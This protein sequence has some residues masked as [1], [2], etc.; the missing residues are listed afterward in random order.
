MLAF[1]FD[2]ALVASER[3][4]SLATWRYTPTGQVETRAV[5][6]VAEESL[7]RCVALSG[8]QFAF[9]AASGRVA[10]SSFDAST[11]V[12]R[13]TSELQPRQQTPRACLLLRFTS[14]NSRLLAGFAKQ[15]TEPCLIVWDTTQATQLAQFG[16]N[17][18]LHS[19]AWLNNSDHAFLAAVSHKWIR[20]YD[21]RRM[22]HSSSS[23]SIATDSSNAAG[24]VIATKAVYGIAPDPFDDFRFASYGDASTVCIWDT[25]KTA[26]PLLTLDAGMNTELRGGIGGLDWCPTR[27]GVLASVSKEGG[28]VSVWELME[29]VSES[30]SGKQSP[31]TTSI[32]PEVE[33]Y[34]IGPTESESGLSTP[35][36][37]LLA[38]ETPS[39]SLHPTSDSPTTLLTTPIL[40]KQRYVKPSQSNS[41]GT[42]GLAWLP[43]SVTNAADV[44]VTI[45]S[46]DGTLS[47]HNLMYTPVAAWGA[48]AGSGAGNQ[49]AVGVGA[50]VSLRDIGGGGEWDED[51]AS[52]IK[53][54]AV[55]GYALDIKTNISLLQRKI[56]AESSQ[57]LLE[58]WTFIRDMR[59]QSRHYT[60]NNREYSLLGIH[61]LVC[62]HVHETS[63]PS[64][65]ESEY[66][67]EI[68][69]GVPTIMTYFESYSSEFRTAGL[70]M[71]GRL[72]ETDASLELKLQSFEQKG[73][74]EQAAGFALFYS[75]S[76][77]RALASLNSSKD[78]K[79]RLVAAALAGYMSGGPPPPTWV[80]LCETL[81]AELKDAYLR[82]LFA[83]M[84]SAGDWMQVL[85]MEGGLGLHD[86]VGIALRFLPDI[87]LLEYIDRCAHDLTN[88][89]DLR[90]LLLTG[91]G[92]SEFGTD[93]LENYIQHTGD[94]QSAV[95]LEVVGLGIR[96]LKG[97]DEDSSRKI[98]KWLEK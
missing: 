50:G 70:R 22:H 47:T 15:K 13:N 45:D 18:A 35:T 61:E 10:L 83:L 29:S 81:S 65:P 6:R 69:G 32:L 44:L 49:L 39:P 80:K 7:V 76:F 90:G 85:E 40:H 58:S 82:S 66:L 8:L 98:F 31:N 53:R 33:G 55:D 16:G 96:G 17:E 59:N 62:D 28:V 56:Y 30:P 74:F 1:S 71:C 78:D 95:L 93:L 42:T 72:F 38:P 57:H 48:Y 64:T 84:G 63:K 54:R 60:L 89:G 21:I 19:A 92:A 52:V 41:S 4:A 9:G 36:P 12:V 11:G 94:V 51:I 43:R 73:N 2:H 23:N 25:R 27:S 24:T 77:D 67:K 91:V 5:S 75:S 26:V 14:S 34:T 97:V 68:V 37:Q 79:L 20:L 46:E 88:K 3:G 86:R 87:Q